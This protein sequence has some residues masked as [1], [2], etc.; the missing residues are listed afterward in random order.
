MKLAQAKLASLEGR[1]EP[2]M[3]EQLFNRNT[4]LE[5]DNERLPKMLA[6]RR[7]ATPFPADRPMTSKRDLA[8]RIQKNSI[9]TGE[10]ILKVL[11]ESGTLTEEGEELTVPDLIPDVFLPIPDEG[12]IPSPSRPS[13]GDSS[14][15]SKKRRRNFSGSVIT[16]QESQ[17]EESCSKY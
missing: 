9:S 2:E 13:A 17:A 3:A 15:P 5:E 11:K 12:E 6:E 7:P 10:F 8:L 1:M 16:C 4:E 14:E